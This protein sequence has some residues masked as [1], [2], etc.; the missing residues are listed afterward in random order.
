MAHAVNDVVL[1]SQTDDGTS[2]NDVKLISTTDEEP[3][4]G[5]DTNTG[6]IQSIGGW[7]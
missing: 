5:G 3:A 4:D 2:N 1:R 6:W 7:W